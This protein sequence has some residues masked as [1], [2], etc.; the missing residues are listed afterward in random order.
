MN[1]EDFLTDYQSEKIYYSINQNSDEQIN[2][3][4]KS[5]LEELYER[6]RDDYEDEELQAGMLIMPNAFAAKVTENDGKDPHEITNI[7]LLRYIKGK[8]D[9]YIRK[10]GHYSSIISDERSE[11]YKNAIEVAIHDSEESLK[12][13]IQ[14]KSNIQTRFQ[15]TVLKKLIDNLWHIKLNNLFQYV[16]I[17]FY[18]P[19]SAV[20]VEDLQ[21]IYRELNEAL[22]IEEKKLEERQSNKNEEER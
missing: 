15:L 19:I 5:F 17:G 21:D 2:E 11:I 1:V 4:I 7:N 14:S 10:A 6:R 20:E 18:S 9:F 3:Q 22:E 8:K 12:L 13:E 16:E